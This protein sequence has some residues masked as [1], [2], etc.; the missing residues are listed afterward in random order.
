MYKNIELFNSC[1]QTILIQ[2]TT[3][4]DGIELYLKELDGKPCTGAF[5][6][7]LEELPTIVQTLQEMM[8]YINR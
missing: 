8:L 1:D 4:F 3:E 5:Y 7:T 6:I 2:P